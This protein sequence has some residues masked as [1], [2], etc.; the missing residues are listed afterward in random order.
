MVTLFKYPD[1][2]TERILG[3]H[4]GSGDLKNFIQRYNDD[5]KKFKAPGLQQPTIV[6][7]DND[8]GG[9]DVG[10]VV[11]NI[12]KKPVTWQEPFIYVTRNL[13]LMATPLVG[14]K[15][16]AIEDFF[17][18]ATLNTQLSG[19]TFQKDPPF[20]ASKH[21]GKAIFAEEVVKK[22]ASAIDFTGFTPVLDNLAAILADY[23]TKQQ[24]QAVP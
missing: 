14:G 2:S 15:D 3:L 19:K 18:P 7:V 13:Y 21:C 16:S 6:L 17:S 24:T 22:N 5:M 23:A 11:S 1:T 12:I 9:H 4:G 10:G 8:K 20:D